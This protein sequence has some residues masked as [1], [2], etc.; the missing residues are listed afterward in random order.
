MSDNKNTSEE[1]DLIKL[2]SLIGNGI[3]NFF[4][5]IFNFLKLLVH[6]LILGLV[7]IRK[8]IIVIGVTTA[9][10]GALGYYKD[11]KSEIYY[12]SSML[13]VLN[14]ESGQEMYNQIRYINTLIHKEDVDQIAKIFSITNDKA[15]SLSGFRIAP[16]DKQ[17]NGLRMYD[18]FLY[19]NDTLVTN[20]YDF[21]GFLKRVKDPDYRNQEITAFAKDQT[22]F[23]KLNQGFINLVETDYFKNVLKLK[24][25]E[26]SL[27]ENAFKKNLA[28][29]DSI[30]IRNNKVAILNAKKEGVSNYTNIDVSKQHSK[31][32][33]SMFEELNNNLKM[34]GHVNTQKIEENEIISIISEFT[35]G[36]ISEGLINNRGL[37]YGLFG[38][39]VSLL[40]LLGLKF[41]TYLKNY[42]K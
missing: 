17:K 10:G 16:Y 40:A 38:F 9:I 24:K 8:N 42:N 14:F 2:F 15:S 30:R 34:L 36:E 12:E 7:F 26:L 29:L 31:E 4:K 39:I 32:E 22:V 25:E 23:V 11:L 1:I 20:K 28:G 37:K 13:T 3:K 21:P 27:K 6:N 18:K 35:V 33:L 41:N 5:G 19:A